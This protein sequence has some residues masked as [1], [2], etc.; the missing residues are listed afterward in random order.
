MFTEQT[1]ELIVGLETPAQATIS[2][3]V[4]NHQSGV[5]FQFTQT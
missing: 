2:N 3:L 1:T 4:P 5:P